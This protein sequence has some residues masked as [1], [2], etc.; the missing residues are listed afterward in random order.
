MVLP[1]IVPWFFSLFFLHAE[2]RTDRLLWSKCIA[3]SWIFSAP[4]GCWDG[5]GD[6]MGC[7]G[8]KTHGWMVNMKKRVVQRRHLSCIRCLL[9]IYPTE[10]PRD[11]PSNLAFFL[12]VYLSDHLSVCLSHLYPHCTPNENSPPGNSPPGCW[13]VCGKQ[14][15]HRLVRVCGW[16][17]VFLSR[18]YSHFHPPQ[19][20]INT[21]RLFCCARQPN[22]PRGRRP[23]KSNEAQSY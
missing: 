20:T 5:V 12:P 1:S 8:A 18:R 13:P 21:R 7:G 22:R 23:S 19:P 3:W 10:R 11:Q 14:C 16:V 2:I 15:C 4:E 9:S 6:E 17:R